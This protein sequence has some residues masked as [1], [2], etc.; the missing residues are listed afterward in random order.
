VASVSAG[1]RVTLGGAR[2]SSSRPPTIKDPCLSHAIICCYRCGE[3]EGVV[4]LRC[5]EA[6]TD[7]A[8]RTRSSR[9]PRA[10]LGGVRLWVPCIYPR[11]KGTRR[12]RARGTSTT[13]GSSLLLCTAGSSILLLSLWS[14]LEL[15]VF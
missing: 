9:R 4:V 3:G 14:G 8:L 15:S 7:I 13:A 12:G 5:W 10:A 6:A 1:W 2:T 11:S